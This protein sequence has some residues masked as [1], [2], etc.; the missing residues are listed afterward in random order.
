MRTT[1]LNVTYELGCR[2]PFSSINEMKGI[3]VDPLV[4]QVNMFVMRFLLY[5]LHDTFQFVPIRIQGRG[6][7]KQC[8]SVQP[9][10]CDEGSATPAG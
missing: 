9:G 10:S 8:S 5:I 6:L 7:N 4:A 3:S 2:P 1:R